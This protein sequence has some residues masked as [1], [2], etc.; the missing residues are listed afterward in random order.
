MKLRRGFK[1]ELR[2]VFALADDL[3]PGIGDPD[4]IQERQENIE[5][6]RKELFSLLDTFVRM[7]ELAC[8]SVRDVVPRTA[9][10]GKR[11]K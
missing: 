8:P 6:L 2:E 3:C 4:T 10:P 7:T 9:R 11:G 5:V 1:T